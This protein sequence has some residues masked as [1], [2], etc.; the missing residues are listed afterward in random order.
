VKY[1]CRKRQSA[2]DIVINKK[3]QGSVATNLRYGGIFNDHFTLNLLLRSL[4]KYQPDSSTWRSMA[5]CAGVLTGSLA[6][7]PNMALRPLVIR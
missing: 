2:N 4:V 3:S 5:W 1:N 7:C 6:T